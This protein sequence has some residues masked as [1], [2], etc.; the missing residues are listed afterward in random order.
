MNHCEHCNVENNTITNAGNSGIHTAIAIG[1][2]GG[3]AL[4]STIGCDNNTIR[5]NTVVR[6]GAITLGG[7]LNVR[8]DHNLVTGNT[9]VNAQKTAII[10]LHARNNT[11]EGNSVEGTELYWANAITAAGSSYNIIRNNLLMDP[12]NCCIQIQTSA[13]GVASN[14]NVITGNTMDSPRVCWVLINETVNTG[15]QIIGN[16]LR[17]PSPICPDGIVDI[18]TNTLIA[19]NS[20]YP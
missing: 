11:F 19:S 15:N 9:I 7:Y 17:N 3:S 20:V 8:G 5:S 6:S 1:W 4:G 12:N 18:G 16:H 14:H 13:Y 10:L 2:G